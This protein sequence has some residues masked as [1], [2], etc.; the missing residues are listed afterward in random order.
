MKAPLDLEKSGERSIAP[1]TFNP[2]MGAEK[3]GC[4]AVDSAVQTLNQFIYL[5]VTDACSKIDVD[6]SIGPGL[7]DAAAAM[8]Q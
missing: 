1:R 6:P 3:R 4:V 5:R 8:G 2:A 7:C